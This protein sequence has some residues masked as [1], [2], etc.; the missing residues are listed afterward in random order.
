MNNPNMTV[1]QFLAIAPGERPTMM[2]AE[3]L[4]NRIEELEV[5]RDMLVD[6][7]QEAFDL[8]DERAIIGHRSFLTAVLHPATRKAMVAERLRSGVNPALQDE[9][10]AK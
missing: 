8:I 2:D 9:K 10:Q 1:R 7:L 4:W 5:E 3:A 6:A